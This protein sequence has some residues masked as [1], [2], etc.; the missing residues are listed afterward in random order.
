M[1]DDISPCQIQSRPACL[2][3][4]QEDRH[5]AFIERFYKFKSFLL[6][7][8]TGYLVI[9][10]SPFFKILLNLLEHGR[11]LR[12]QQSPVSPVNQRIYKFQTELPLGGRTTVIFEH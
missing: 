2:E 4:D 12:E 11:E 6:R 3:R 10:D 7:R 9:L 5:I 1:Y 8:R